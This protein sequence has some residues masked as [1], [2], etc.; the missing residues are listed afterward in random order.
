[1]LCR[2]MGRFKLDALES[3][4]SNSEL[5][6]PRECRSSKTECL[7]EGEDVCSAIESN[8][9]RYTL[10]ASLDVLFSSCKFLS[11]SHIM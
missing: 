1:M 7:S 5:L 11:V 10:L 3:P 8:A 9:S 4:L 6:K 2:P